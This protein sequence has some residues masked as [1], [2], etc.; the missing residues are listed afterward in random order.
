MNFQSFHIRSHLASEIKKKKPTYHF[1]PTY[2]RI[3]GTYNITLEWR[4]ELDCALISDIKYVRVDLEIFRNTHPFTDDTII[5]YG[6]M[7]SL[8]VMK[9][10]CNWTA[11]GV[12]GGAQ[13]HIMSSYIIMKKAL[14]KSMKFFSVK[15]KFYYSSI[16]H[17]IE[18]DWLCKHARWF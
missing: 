7:V 12:L 15:Y 1:F 10:F 14:L 4:V 11:C 3:T 13:A 16:V 17:S 8:V 9:Q 5:I 6:T 2:D 18:K